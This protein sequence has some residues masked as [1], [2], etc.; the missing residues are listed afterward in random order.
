MVMEATNSRPDGGLSRDLQKSDEWVPAAASR[1]KHPH[2]GLYARYG[3]RMLDIAGALVLLIAFLPLMLMI[4]A[5]LMSQRGPVMFGH[6]RI[7]YRGEE[8]SCLK[9]RTMVV[10]AE[11]R[12]EELLA[13]DPEAKRQ[14]LADRKLD[15][16]PRITASGHLLRKTS[17][18]ELPQLLNV[19]R[20]EMSLVGPRP[21][22]AAEL[23]KYGESAKSYTSLRPGLTGKWQVSGRN[24]V[25]Y[26][27]RVA[28]DDS[29]ARSFSIKG[30][31]ILLC[32]TVA[33]VLG[34][35]GK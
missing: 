16:D 20:G 2:S 31:I 28:M 15:H 29:Y 8:F 10:D 19:L 5:L 7:G 13:R 24:D 6:R 26:A 27:C 25:S 1:G 32:R 23:K 14:W 4:I 35:T 30:D 3:K 33:V 18:D 12:L 34:A 11:E 21:V 22:T 17:L 9:F